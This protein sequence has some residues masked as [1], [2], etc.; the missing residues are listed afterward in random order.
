MQQVREVTSHQEGVKHV[1]PAKAVHDGLDRV[2]LEV[3]GGGARQV[4]GEES[5]SWG[6]SQQPFKFINNRK[7]DPS[8]SEL[9]LQNKKE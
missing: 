2:G 4:K 9:F 8:W 6:N 5:E 7:N 3:L 1:I